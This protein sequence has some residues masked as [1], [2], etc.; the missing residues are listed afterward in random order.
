MVRPCKLVYVCVLHNNCCLKV[1]CSSPAGQ[2]SWIKPDT[3]GTPHE[4][5][6][7]S[8]PPAAAALL[9]RQLIWSSLT[10]CPSDSCSKRAVSAAGC[11]KYPSQRL[12]LQHRKNTVH[13]LGR[14]IAQ[15]FLSAT[16]ERRRKALTKSE[17][18]VAP[19]NTSMLGE[20]SG[21]TGGHHAE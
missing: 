7:A 14:E 6:P 13:E 2:A 12:Q 16:S 15:P 9:G 19:L 21:R 17:E 5:L 4:T 1:C 10:A 20:D 18:A 3:T 11:H 8:P